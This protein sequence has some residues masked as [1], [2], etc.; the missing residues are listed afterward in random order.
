MSVLFY[1]SASGFSLVQALVQIMLEQSLL[2]AT[3]LLEDVMF[4]LF[5]LKE[6]ILKSS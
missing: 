6:K 4:N 3:T 2:K 1:C 5:M